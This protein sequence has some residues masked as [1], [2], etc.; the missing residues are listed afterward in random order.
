MSVT[1]R[2]F[3]I[4]RFSTHDGP[5]I[6]TTVFLK[7]CPL[8]CAWCH[9]PEGISPRPQLSF[10]PG[11]CGG[12]GE[13][14]RVCGRQA[15]TIG[16]VDGVVVHTLDR[17]RCQACGLCAEACDAGC[18]E[19]VGREMNVGQVMDEVLADRVFYRRSG[20]GLT[21]SG[22]E[23]LMQTDFTAA[24]LQAARE[25]GLHCCVQTCGS[26]NWERLQRVLP[27]VDLFLY[28]Y[29]E[30]DAARHQQ[31]TGHSNDLILRNLRRLHDEGAEVCLHCPIVPGFNDTEE[32]IAGIAA[33]AQSMPRLRGVRILPYHALG[34]GKL[35][36]FGLAPSPELPTDPPNRA[37]VEGWITRLQDCGIRVLNIRG[38]HNPYAMVCRS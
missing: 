3:D 26:V 2:V 18:L 10:T 1:G 8:C 16:I 34:G 36:R 21:V 17:T 28:D 20:G 25:H 19:M 13:C 6:R 11:K 35:E 7:G 33:L 31:F 4:Q 22:G 23:P 30:T 14:A 32:H 29:K 38:P 12:C 27:L 37:R 15:H 9:N 5:G 24:L